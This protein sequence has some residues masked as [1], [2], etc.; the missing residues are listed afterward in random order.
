M[1]YAM[2]KNIGAFNMPTL[3]YLFGLRICMFMEKGS[4][5]DPHFHIFLGNTKIASVSIRD[6]VLLAGTLSNTE[7]KIIRGFTNEY[8]AQLLDSWQKLQLGELP[9]KINVE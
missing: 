9:P 3:C 8:S 6:G 5:K 2:L 1:K 7:R 4:H